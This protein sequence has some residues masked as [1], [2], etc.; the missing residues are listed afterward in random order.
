MLKL[1]WSQVYKY[2]IGAR[3]HFEYV[4]VNVVGKQCIEGIAVK[5][6]KDK[7]SCEA[8][9]NES[10]ILRKLTS[11]LPMP[12]VPIPVNSQRFPKLKIEYANIVNSKRGKCKIGEEYLSESIEIA[13]M[14]NK[15]DTENT[16]QD[17]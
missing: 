4:H 11:I 15:F 1:T 2:I 5:Y 6:G 14:Y 17:Y 7:Y 13:N 16:M 12:G 9:D 10:K 8:L 3:E